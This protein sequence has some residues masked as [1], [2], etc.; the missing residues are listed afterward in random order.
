M[1]TIPPHFH[2]VT[3]DHQASIRITDLGLMAGEI[4]RQ[5][6]EAVRAWATANRE[7]LRQEW[8]RLNEQ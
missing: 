7:F 6:L 4:D 5:S 8:S 1:P 3:P 2:I